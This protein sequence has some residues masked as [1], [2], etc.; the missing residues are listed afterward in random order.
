MITKPDA[1]A[2]MWISSGFIDDPRNV[3]RRGAA[4]AFMPQP[5]DDREIGMLLD[6]AL[7]RGIGDL[8]GIKTRPFTSMSIGA[9][10]AQCIEPI[11]GFNQQHAGFGTGKNA[12]QAVGSWDIAGVAGAVEQAFA[13]GESSQIAAAANVVDHQAAIKLTAAGV[14]RRRTAGPP[15][16][17]VD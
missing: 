1:K 8:R 3:A 15:A 11:A 17:A 4:G 5:V 9:V 16:D 13:G 10:T 6:Q 7:E 2:V 12:L 14:V